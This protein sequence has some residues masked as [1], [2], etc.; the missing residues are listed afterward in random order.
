MDRPFPAYKGDEPYIFVSYAHNDDDIVYSEIQWLKDQGFN[1]W[2]DEGISPGSEWHN[3]LANRIQNSSLFIFFITPQSV[4]SENCQREVHY[5]IDHGKPLLAIHLEETELPVG[6]DLS[7]GSTQA[8]VRH[9]ISELD[10]RIKLLQSVNDYLQRGISTSSTQLNVAG[11]SGRLLVGVTF[12]VALLVGI[13]SWNL[14]PTDHSQSPDETTFSPRTSINIGFSGLQAISGARTNIALSSDGYQLAYTKY[15]DGKV[16]IYLRDIDKL[17]ARL[18]GEHPT[19]YGSLFFSPDGKWL[20]FHAPTG[21]MKVSVQGGLSQELTSGLVPF[22]GSWRNNQKILFSKQDDTGVGLLYLSMD[23]GSTVQATKSMPGD[24][25]LW[26]HELPVKNAVLVTKAKKGTTINRSDI[27]LLNLATGESR[28]LIQA[29]YNARYAPSGHIVFMRSG[30]LWA[31]P[32]SLDRLEITGDEVPVV[33]GIQTR[34]G[35]GGAVYSFS[36]DGRLVYLPVEATGDFQIKLVWIDRTGREVSSLEMEPGAYSLP[37]ISP[38]GERVAMRVLQPDGKEDIWTYHLKRQSFS[39]ITS[40]G[41]THHPIWTSDSKDLIFSLRRGG[42]QRIAADGTSQPEEITDPKGSW[43]EPNFITSDGQLVYIVQKLERIDLHIRSVDGAQK[44]EPLLDS[45][46]DERHATISSDG[47]WMAYISDETGQ[48]EVYVRPFPDVKQNKWKISLDGGYHPK[49][50]PDGSELFYFRVAD[51][52]LSVVTIRTKPDF[53]Y[54]KPELMFSGRHGLR[55]GYDISHD[56]QQF[57]IPSFETE[58]FES[59]LTSLVVVE[60]WFEELKRLAPPDPS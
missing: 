52:S 57:L 20:A 9:E 31:A 16:N 35:H 27:I 10:Y 50:S 54:G 22:G 30:S 58:E 3:E 33:Q 46:F 41:I 48:Y 38:N 59:K 51:N 53:D 13:I 21:L 14:K 8:I 6:I 32:F 45:T 11:Y 12:A 44:G 17:N 18:I 5:A 28:N 49:W 42:M 23:D 39:R 37:V 19:T 40:T 60:N 7:L 26:P 55:Y 1:I 34:I 47:K 25:F 4:V 29:G 24:E 43:H 15:I 56:G 2:Y 36:E